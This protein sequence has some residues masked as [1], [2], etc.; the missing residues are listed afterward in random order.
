[1]LPRQESMS[2]LHRYL[3]V[4]TGSLCASELFFKI[5]LLTNK[6]LNG[7]GP[8]Y[9]RDLLGYKNSGS[10][11]RSSNNRLLVE[12]MAN[13]KT[14]GDRAYSVAGLKLWNNLP[15]D[16]RLSSSVTVFNTKLKTYLFKEAF[17]L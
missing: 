17:E 14:Y 8:S 9:I 6:V 12:P 10:V 5:L 15:L 7:Q 1:M 16:I 4:Y 2:I 11:L 3:S 13:L